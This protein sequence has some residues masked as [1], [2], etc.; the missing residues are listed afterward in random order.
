MYKEKFI[1]SVYFR[2]QYLHQFCQLLFKLSFCM[3]TAEKTGQDLSLYSKQRN[4][5]QSR[6]FLTVFIN[7]QFWR[8]GA[9]TLTFYDWTPLVSISRIFCTLTC[10]RESRVYPPH[11]SYSNYFHKDSTLFKKSAETRPFFMNTALYPWNEST[12]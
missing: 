9:D 10:A 2:N 7:I 11:L 4:R 1:Y 3:E 6:L 8:M 5:G 12:L